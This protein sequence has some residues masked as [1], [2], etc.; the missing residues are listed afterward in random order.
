VSAAPTPTPV[1]GSSP[2]QAAEG[3]DAVAAQSLGP[4][5]GLVG[6]FE[7]VTGRSGVLSGEGGHPG[8]E[9]DHPGAVVDV[10]DGEALEAVSHALGCDDWYTT[11]VTTCDELDQALATASEGNA[12]CYIE[13]VTDKYAA[14]PL[15]EKLHENIKTLYPA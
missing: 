2:L 3:L 13:V 1:R 8:A 7:H 4:V 5:Q 14:S 11:R 9:G 10:R 6:L 12:A 15:S